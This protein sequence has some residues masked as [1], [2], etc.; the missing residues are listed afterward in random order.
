MTRTTVGVGAKAQ[1][2]WQ[3]IHRALFPLGPRQHADLAVATSDPR[4]HLSSMHGGV[5]KAVARRAQQEGCTPAVH[6][7]ILL[8]EVPTAKTYLGSLIQLPDV[9]AS[10]EEGL[11][12]RWADDYVGDA[13]CAALGP[14]IRHRLGEH[15]TP[16]AVVRAVLDPLPAA[17]RLC[18]PACG[19][20]RFLVEALRDGRRPA[21][22]CGF[23][24]NPVAV[25][26]TRYEVW[27]AMGRPAAV[28]R[29]TV[30][31]ADFLLDG[32]ASQPHAWAPGSSSDSLP[33]THFVGNPPWVLWRNLSDT[34]RHLVGE[35]FANTALNQ[36]RGWGA[37]V[38]AGQTD[39]SYLFLHEALERVA[40]GGTVNLVLPKSVYKSPV[41]ASVIRSGRTASGRL[42]GYTEVVEIHRGH[43]FTDVRTDAVIGRAR[44]D[45]PMTF[46][47]PWIVT[48][49]SGAANSQPARPSDPDDLSSPWIV[50]ESATQLVLAQGTAR[51]RYKGRGGINTGGGNGVLYVEEI[52]R[53]DGGN[54]VRVRN[55]PSRGQ[56][57]R[58]VEAVVEAAMVRPL[59]KGTGVQPWRTTPSHAVIFPQDPEDVRRALPEHRL[60]ETAPRLHEYLGEFRHQLSSR[61]ELAR[62]GGE[63]YSIFRVGPYTVDGWRV[64]WPTSGANRLRAAVVPDGSRLVPDQKVV[65]VSFDDP[66]AAF[67]LAALLNSSI[68]R[69]AVLD[70]S[71][72]DASPSLLSRLPLPEWNPIQSE[73]LAVAR[74]GAA[75]HQQGGADPT[76][77]D[78]LVNVLF[79]EKSVEN[80]R[81]LVHSCDH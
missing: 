51:G 73:H 80:G 65:V 39:L 35:I 62:W 59:L 78:E 19:D 2:D 6:D 75:A 10:I 1:S 64:V 52:E 15:Y 56:P 25:V 27:K 57:E 21:D 30:E 5:V 28:P 34:Y 4:R 26:M 47:V 22:V 11:A 31:W 37:R 54:L 8:Q 41:G 61:K 45:T 24:V 70:A 77:I 3:L 12:E 38:S 58:T 49:G 79:D 23:D 9:A 7:W 32:R 42:F 67:F 60:I 18:D 81:D 40:D 43:A 16:P 53:L 44:A 72:L 17:G 69:R 13:Y 29:V 76:V 68:V 74:A 55:L 36:A 71:A 20:G 46:P 33:I 66:H 63:W 48:N 50:G 14:N